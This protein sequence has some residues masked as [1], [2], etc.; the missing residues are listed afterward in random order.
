MRGKKIRH[1]V[2]SRNIA[3]AKRR[4]SDRFNICSVKRGSALAQPLTD[5]SRHLAVCFCPRISHFR[6]CFSFRVQRLVLVPIVERHSIEATRL[7]RDPW[8]SWLRLTDATRG[9]VDVRSLPLTQPL[10]VVSGQSAVWALGCTFCLK[11]STLI[12]MFTYPFRYPDLPVYVTPKRA[13]AMSTGSANCRYTNSLTVGRNVTC[14]P[15]SGS[16]TS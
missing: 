16:S 1:S 12:L 13:R 5:R 4:L 9:A 6:D 11:T 8:F 7:S 10:H 15:P 14:T 3:R 2:L